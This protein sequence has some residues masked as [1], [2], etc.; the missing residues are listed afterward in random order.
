MS[1]RQHL[2]QI[3]A[4]AGQTHHNTILP[5][6][7]HKNHKSF[8]TKNNGMQYWR[9]R[10]IRTLLVILGLFIVVR[11]AFEGPPYRNQKKKVVQKDVP[12]EDRL[13][14]YSAAGD[15]PPIEVIS[16]TYTSRLNACAT[17]FLHQA[18]TNHTSAPIEYRLFFQERE[19]TFQGLPHFF[20][21]CEFVV[22][23]FVVLHQQQQL[24]DGPL[25][26]VRSISMMRTPND[27]DR[28]AARRVFG[29]SVEFLDE[30]QPQQQQQ[31]LGSNVLAIERSHCP[32]G[33]INKM[34][35]AYMTQFPT[36]AW[37]RACC[38]PLPNK[39]LTVAYIDRQLSRRRSLPPK[40]HQW[41]VQ[42]LSF[43]P[44]WKFRHLIMERLSP[45]VQIETMQNVDIL[46]ALHGNGLT[47]QIWMAPESAVL[48]LFDIYTGYQHDYATTAIVLRH[49]YL[50]VTLHGRPVGNAAYDYDVKWGE[51]ERWSSYEMVDSRF[52]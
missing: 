40:F 39:E 1:V 37:H 10:S 11:I 6:N 22:I 30:T 48:E 33:G 4:S 17:L 45:S 32:T 2:H 36:D 7:Y 35:F 18:S 9:C 46:V 14:N 43:H 47:H 28:E 41:L 24:H 31:L 5:P 12:L 49:H 29:S 25:F 21:F 20:H 19:G 26:V 13:F 38:S 3:H 15:P 34:W 27:L 51:L 44:K 16:S 23:S 8:G 52:P 50:G 42:Y